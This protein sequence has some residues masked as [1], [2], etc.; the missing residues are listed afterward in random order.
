MFILKLK[1]I[2]IALS[3]CGCVHAR[4]DLSS[5]VNN[6]RWIGDKGPKWQ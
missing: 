2:Y 3:P 1:A 6:F 4:L 5:A